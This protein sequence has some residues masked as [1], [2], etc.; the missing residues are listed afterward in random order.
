MRDVKR[1][2][3]IYTTYKI[4]NWG[5]CIFGILKASSQY[6][7]VI[8][9]NLVQLA[10]QMI[11]RLLKSCHFSPYLANMT[12]TLTAT[13]HDLRPV[14]RPRT[15]LQHPRLRIIWYQHHQNR[16]STCWDT[17]L[18]VLIWFDAS[19]TYFSMGFS[20]IWHVFLMTI[21]WNARFR[22]KLY[23]VRMRKSMIPCKR[24][25]AIRQLG[26]SAIRRFSD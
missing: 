8:T 15:L 12:L 16:I 17:L 5:F 6:F 24:D 7:L 9:S 20:L 11:R 19:I 22:G 25:S 3:L 26:D 4:S 13:E 21:C 18:F 14:Q 1:K 2:L 23:S 10:S